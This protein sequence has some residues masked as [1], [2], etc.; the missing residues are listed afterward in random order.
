MRGQFAARRPIA[1]AALEARASADVLEVRAQASRR[2]PE[3][4]APRSTARSDR[5]ND[6]PEQVGHSGGSWL[7]VGTVPTQL[8]AARAP[9]SGK[10]RSRSRV[11][12]RLR[13]RTQQLSSLATQLSMIADGP[14]MTSSGM[15]CGGAAVGVRGAAGEGVSLGR[16][17][18]RGGV[19]CARPA[20]RPM[21]TIAATSP[22]RT[23]DRVSLRNRTQPPRSWFA[24]LASGC[25]SPHPIER[26]RA[27]SAG[28]R[29]WRSALDRGVKSRR[30]RPT[31]AQMSSRRRDRQRV[32][33]CRRSPDLKWVLWPESMVGQ[34][35]AF[36]PTSDGPVV[37]R[38]F[39]RRPVW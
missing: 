16:A 34:V 19:G 15:A 18:G 10:A 13:H 4:P 12:L 36:D 35:K 22:E 6:R 9:R 33:P 27:V 14:C 38:R 25:T 37:L 7:P 5:Q 8:L 31:M 2:Q 39:S 17:G 28:A 30:F 29:A 1:I 20:P 26:G 24:T 23:I 32:V 11:A 21:R 3:R